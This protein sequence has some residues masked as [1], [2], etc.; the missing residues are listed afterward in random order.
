MAPRVNTLTLAA[1]LTATLAVASYQPP[2]PLAAGYLLGGGGAT[3]VSTSALSTFPITGFDQAF[4]GDVTNARNWETPAGVL[5]NLTCWTSVAPGAAKSYA[6]ALYVNGAT[7][8]LTCT[9]SGA[10]TT[11]CSDTTHTVSNGTGTTGNRLA[12]SVTPS[13]T[14]TAAAVACAVKFVK[15]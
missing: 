7:S 12:F 11:T 3:T 5:S 15:D 2:G 8:A 4:L 9:V 1:L 13:G 10:A 14:P 6:F